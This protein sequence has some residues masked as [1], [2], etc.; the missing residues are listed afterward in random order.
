MAA[1]S[2][3]SGTGQRGHSSRKQLMTCSGIQQTVKRKS[4][5]KSVV[6]VFISLRMLAVP[7]PPPFCFVATRLSCRLTVKK[8][9][10]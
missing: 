6:A 4:T 2:S 7:C 1:S 5:R 9:L 8:I 3:S 10:A